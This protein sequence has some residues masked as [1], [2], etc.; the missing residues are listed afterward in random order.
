MGFGT[1]S[2]A[3]SGLAAAV[4]R[5]RTRAH[6]PSQAGSGDV[7]ALGTQTLSRAGGGVATLVFREG[8]PAP[9]DLA[10][11][12]ADQILAERQAQASLRVL[13]SELDLKGRL[14]NLKG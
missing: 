13:A 9:L 8:T 1:T 14:V 7:C 4:T 12:L 6:G 10:R 3:R 11:A 2:I 5:L